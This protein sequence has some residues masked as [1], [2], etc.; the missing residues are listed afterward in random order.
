ML[1]LNGDILSWIGDEER[2]FGGFLDAS[3]NLYAQE[4]PFI[5]IRGNHETRGI[6]ARS[7][8]S[9]FPHSSG[10]SYYSFT[11]GEVHF[12]VLDCGEDKPDDHP[13]YAGIVDFDSFRTEQAEWLAREVQTE[14]FKK[15][16]YRIVLFHIPAYSKSDWHGATEVTNK[17][18][19]ILNRA[20]VDLV[21]NGHTHRFERIN[22]TTGKN[23]F[24]ILITGK[25][26]ILETQVSPDELS[27]TV[28]NTEGELVDSFTLAK[29]APSNAS[30]WRLG[31]S[32]GNIFKL[33]Q[34]KVKELAAAGFTD[35]EVGFGRINNRDDLKALNDQVK[36]VKKWFAEEDINIWSIH[37]PYGRDIDI[38]LIDEGDRALAVQELTSLFKAAR[39]LEPE[40]L[41]IHPSFEPIPDEERADRLKA[42]IS[43]LPQLMKIAS[44]YNMELTIEDLPRSCL[45]NTSAEMNQILAAVPG[46]TVCC[47]VNHLLQETTE[48]FIDA[49]GSSIVTLHICDYDGIDERH[50]L[51]GK[52]I[53]NWNKVLES[54]ELAAYDGPFMFESAGTYQ[55]KA[56]VWAKMKQDYEAYKNGE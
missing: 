3:V 51:P 7:I 35:V 42:C 31:T 44:K 28:T 43:T 34:E 29:Q 9:Y 6:G 18:G 23:N 24:P 40:K 22:K 25:K 56:A 41:V 49:V 13:V 8:M 21:I 46:L 32:V 19:P 47:D 15:A 12:T 38:S 11:Q 39:P 53:I 27:C 45:G 20:K 26:M 36:T 54:L 4:K 55:E 1:F 50:W 17:W 48:A 2:I 52:G 16:G 5:F 30:T 10:R 33:S 37:I 14:A